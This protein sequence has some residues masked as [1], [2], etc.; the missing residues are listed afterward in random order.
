MEG[1]TKVIT[2]NSFEYLVE[3]LFTGDEWWYDREHEE[4]KRSQAPLNV[5]LQGYE[6]TSRHLRF[7]EYKTGRNTYR[8]NRLYSCGTERYES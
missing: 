2:R 6:Y 4:C 1:N 8:P 5:T 7:T 3:I